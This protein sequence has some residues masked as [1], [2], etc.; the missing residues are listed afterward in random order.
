VS[1]IVEMNARTRRNASRHKFKN[2]GH[3]VDRPNYVRR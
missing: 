3:F 2:R 1:K